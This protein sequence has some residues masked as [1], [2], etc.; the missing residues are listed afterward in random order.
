LLPVDSKI[1]FRNANHLWGKDSF[2]TEDRV[3]EK[4][5]VPE[6]QAIVVGPA[7][8]NLVR[9]ACIENNYWRSA[10]RTG[11]GAVM[12]SKKVKANV[13]HGQAQAEV[14]DPELLKD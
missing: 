7:G 14:A 10:G 13:F 9:F 4:V 8:K 2:E 5:G 6:A 11:M 12:G 3:S 1:E